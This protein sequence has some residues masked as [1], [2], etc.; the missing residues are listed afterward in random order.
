MWYLLKMYIPGPY[1]QCPLIQ[2]VWCGDQ[3]S[4]HRLNNCPG[5]L[6][7][8][9]GPGSSL[10]HLMSKVSLSCKQ[11]R[12]T[13]HDH[14]CFWKSTGIPSRT[15]TLL[16]KQASEKQTPGQLQGLM[17]CVLTKF[18]GCNPNTLHGSEIKVGHWD[19]WPWW[20][21]SESPFCS[22]KTRR[23]LSCAASMRAISKT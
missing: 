19:Q 8:D 4:F 16:N 14:L 23:G 21:M 2:V 6:G 20:K 15:Q 7:G 1:S 10:Y 12:S 18:I 9:L 11:Q 5:W 17:T 22:L 3:H 13:Q